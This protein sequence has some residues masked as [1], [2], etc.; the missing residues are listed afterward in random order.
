MCPPKG[1]AGAREVVVFWWFERRGSYLRYEAR[2]SG[3]GDYELCVV[4][5]EGT[6]RVERFTDSTELAKRQL[7]FERQLAMEGW[8]G[9]HG[10]NL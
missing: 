8:T 3:G 7:E 9:P 5:P 4:S 6:E 2:E 10:W 1:R